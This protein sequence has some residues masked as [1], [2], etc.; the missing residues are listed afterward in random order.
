MIG[1]SQPG[2]RIQRAGFGRGIAAESCGYRGQTC[3]R[4]RRDGGAPSGGER[5]NPLRFG[6]IV[7]ARGRLRP[8]DVRFA[9]VGIGGDRS[10]VMLPGRCGI[11]AFETGA[12]LAQSCRILRFERM[13]GSLQLA[14]QRI[15]QANDAP[16]L[17]C[18]C[19]ERSFDFL[20][21]RVD[22]RRIQPQAAGGT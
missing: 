22:E 10:G 19:R 1:R 4:Q 17:R 9:E 15:G 16:G 20:A 3:A 21:R 6:F 14:D 11:C 5:E 18:S 8:R 12:V 2:Q 13:Y 7:L